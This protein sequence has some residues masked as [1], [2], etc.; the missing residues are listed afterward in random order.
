MFRC[1]E[2]SQSLD[3]LFQLPVRSCAILRGMNNHLKN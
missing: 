2:S 3:S 1:T